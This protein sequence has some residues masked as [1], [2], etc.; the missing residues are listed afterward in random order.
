MK[1][2]SV[3]GNMEEIPVKYTGEGEDVNPELTIEDI[4]EGTKSLAII[5]DDPDSYGKIWVH[6]LVWDILVNGCIRK[7]VETKENPP[8]LITEYSVT[9]A[10][11][12][13]TIKIRENSKLGM[14]G[15]ND[16]NKIK[17]SGPMPPKNSGIHHYFFKVYALD[18]IPEVRKGATC[19][20]LEAEMQGHIIEK[21][22]LVGI[23]ER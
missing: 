21:A 8:K 16:F 4:P 17:Y 20:E 15:R 13:C 2:S 12:F 18:N 19:V 1:I 6:W 11:N 9:D 5:V 7:K 10:E 14:F 3:F 23:Y 22:E